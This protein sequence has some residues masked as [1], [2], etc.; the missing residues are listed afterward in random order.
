M[1]KRLLVLFLYALLLCSSVMPVYE[2]KAEAHEP[3]RLLINEVRLGGAKL[4]L[5]SS[6]E[7]QEY[8]T[9]YNPTDS[10]VELDNWR[11]EYA[12]SSFNADDCSAANW[13]DF[14]STAVVGVTPLSGVIE[15]HAVSTPI[16]RQLND[17]G[18]GSLRLVDTTIPESPVVHDSIGWGAEAPCYE[19]APAIAPVTN[20]TTTNSMIRYLDCETDQPL[21]TN[22]NSNDF[23]SAVSL[24]GLPGEIY[25][26]TC[27]EIHEDTED[28]EDVLVEPPKCEGVVISEILPNPSGT[29]KNNEFI[30]LH[31]PT[32]EPVLLDD[33]KLKTTASTKQYIFAES[34]ELRPGEYWAMYD[35]LTDL[36]L[37]N[38]AGGSVM[39]MGTND[40]FVVD[41]PANLNPGEAWALIDGLWQATLIPTPDNRNVLHAALLND[42][43]ENADEEVLAPCPAG[44]YRNPETNRC[45]NIQVTSAALTPCAVGQVRNPETNRCRNIVSVVNSLVPCRAGQERNP[46][47]NRCRAVQA[48]STQ[49]Q[50]CQEGYERNPETNRCRKVVAPLATA[51]IPSD[52][53]PSS[54][55][56]MNG[57]FLTAGVVGVLGYG[58]YEY[59]RDALNALLRIKAKFPGKPLH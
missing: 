46:E 58:A 36:I 40:E 57:I 52:T 39:L 44:K 23:Y 29:D 34:I 56:P 32:Q 24:P 45:R 3:P 4:A 48:A 13:A 43:E 26:T 11:I 47:T 2:V 53:E 1:N 38:A 33:C 21:D 10:T 25:S 22:D 35:E 12:K 27:E 51:A 50:P 59:R 49:L 6:I 31:N 19:L 8:I 5:D 7:I 41:Y 18:S 14:A 54:P 16:I 9:L 30:E 37:P 55:Q 42:V 17:S 28:A 20:S 15:P